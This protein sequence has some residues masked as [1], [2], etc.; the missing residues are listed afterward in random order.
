MNKKKFFIY[1]RLVFMGD[2]I[3]VAIF[4]DDHSFA[5]S[6]G[7]FLNQQDDFII[8]GIT[9]RLVDALECIL[10]NVPDIVLMNFSPPGFYQLDI[11]KKIHEFCLPK[12]PEFIIMGG[13]GIE[14]IMQVAQMSIIYFLIKPFDFLTAAKRIR[15]LHGTAK[16][17]EIALKWIFTEKHTLMNSSLEIRVSRVLQTMGIQPNILGYQ[18]LKDSIFF[19]RSSGICENAKAAAIYETVASRRNTTPA[20]VERAIQYAKTLYIRKEMQNKDTACFITDILPTNIQF[21]KMISKK[22]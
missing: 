1:K 2:K 12:K 9:S 11:I 14:S 22:I 19:M 8:T 17:R 13:D 18:Y 20:R 6:L 10:G 4:D 21:I 7:M 3:S 5:S 16:G 15:S